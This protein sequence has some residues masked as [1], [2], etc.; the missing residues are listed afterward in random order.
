[1]VT[2]LPKDTQT[3]AHAFESLGYGVLE[4]RYG[5]KTLNL[6]ARPFEKVVL[7]NGVTLNFNT[8]ILKSD[9]VVDLGRRRH[10]S[11]VPWLLG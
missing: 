2:R 11:T 3:P 5:V 8:D 10:R 4:K 1:M 7:D 9:F 6:L